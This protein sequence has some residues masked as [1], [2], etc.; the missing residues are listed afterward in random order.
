MSKIAAVIAEAGNKAY[1]VHGFDGMDEVTLTA[2]S[3]LLRVEDGKIFEE[4]IID[5][6]KFGLKKVALESLKGADPK[7]NAEKLIA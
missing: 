6:E 5:P 1:I 2:N 3:Y 7:Y 4:E